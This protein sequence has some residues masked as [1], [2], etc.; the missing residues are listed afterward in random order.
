M[1][2]K[3]I[4]FRLIAGGC[5]AVILPLL[6][7][8]YLSTNKASRALEHLAT[9][10]ARSGAEDLATLV[11]HILSEEKKIVLA[12]ASD[13][14]VR[15]V[16]QKV[17]DNGI[18][19]TTEDIKTL[20]ADMKRKYKHLGSNYLGIFVTDAS[21]KL[22]TGERAGGKEY[23]GSDVSTRSYF[24]QAKESLKAVVGDVV[25]SKST[26]VLISVVC[27]PILSDSGEFLGIFGMPMKA[28]TL[29]KLVSGKTVGKTGYAFMINSSGVII[30]HPKEQ[31]ILSLDL[32]TLKGMETITR[33]ML[34]GKSG[35]DQYTFK[36]TKK[37]AGYA[38]VEITG[39]SVGI[40][41]NRDELLG[42]ARAIRN[43]TLGIGAISLLLIS[44]LIYFASKA[45][46]R[47][48]NQ[49]VAGLK[50]I[51]EGEGDLTMRLPVAPIQEVGEMA[52]WFNVFI[53]KLQKIISQIADD[54][55]K[56]AQSA[57]GLST[58]SRQ[59]HDN[60]SETSQLSDSVA[61]AAEE[62]SS[63]LNSVAA[64]MEEST[65]NTTMVA[66]AAEEMTATISEIAA[67]S[68]QARDI[69]EQAVKQAENTSEKISELSVAAQAIN[70]VT[71]TITEISE[72]TNLLALNATIEA[73]RAGEAGKGFAVVANEIKELA[74]QTAEAT[75][76][77]KNQINEVQVTTSGTT[78]EIDEICNI[79]KQVNEII[80]TIS[81]SVGE[82]SAATGEIATNISQASQGLGEVNENVNQISV[83]ADSIARD[84]TSVNT[85]SAHIS[86]SSGEVKASADTLHDLSS[87][88]TTIVN[89]FKV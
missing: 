56:V 30:A 87:R 88:L 50:D 19:G 89:N 62:M 73:A 68:E 23:K 65:T 86:A 59:L 11:E 78:K 63:N 67:N 21:G 33:N 38:P 42:A 27:A 35:I 6:V 58:I 31:F 77:I 8:G 10:N 74:K 60:A 36:N 41:Q 75:F 45:L 81:T 4:G 57:T 47:P 34:A 20:R 15:S 69:S 13:S 83:V 52:T 48:I 84:I 26:G 3:S 55:R 70:K 53:E 71:E 37:I 82:Q 61:V 12:L 5:I 64:G 28:S 39:W 80:A 54:S 85:S 40:T 79:I 22:Y 51:A 72:Q 49:A 44:T 14:L 16:A 29:T 25:R 1:N 24:K 18:T 17:K 76:D 66:S 2:T 43:S 32:K 7:V 46:V 9:A